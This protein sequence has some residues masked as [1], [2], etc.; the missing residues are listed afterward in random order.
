MSTSGY[1]V[2]NPATGDTVKT[3]ET[4]GDEALRDAIARAAAAHRDWSR[5]DGRG[6]GEHHRPRRGAAHRAPR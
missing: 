4:S 2:V 5:D 3:Q 1:A 6:A